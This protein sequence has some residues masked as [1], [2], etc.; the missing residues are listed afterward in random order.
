MRLVLNSP[1][2]MHL[3]LR[4]NEMLENV[5]PLSSIYFRG[6]L[7]MPN[8]TPPIFSKDDVLS[9]KKRILKA[10]KCD[11][12]EPF[13][14]VFYSKELNVEKLQQLKD[15]IK[16]VK[17]YPAGV[18]TNSESGLSELD[19]SAMRDVLDFM[20]NNNI[21]LSIHGE[22]NGFILD[23]ESEF[24]PIFENLAKEFPKLKIIMEHISTTTLAN[25]LDKYE[26]LYATITIHHLLFTL[27]DLLGERLNPH[28]FCKPIV[29]TYKDR[30]TLLNL[31]LN[32]HEKVSFGSD[33]A[34]HTK[35]S[36]ECANGSA[37]IFSSPIALLC[38]AE[39]FEKHNKLDNLQKFVSDNAKK[40]YDIELSNKEVVLVKKDF[41]VPENYGTVVPMFAN[42]T[43]SWSYE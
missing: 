28:L 37:G 14:T 42:K 22:T 36:K 15:Y 9:Y 39:L 29:K 16:A 6:G 31:A 32:A 19:F 35:S 8:L 20:S 17:L 30:E 4:D 3:H 26:N 33:S 41:L 34:P 12:F 27:D 38:L 43:I 7:V 40:I 11:D 24:A 23:R 2:D 5:A 18:T 1:F 10:S 21:P 25:L 13:M